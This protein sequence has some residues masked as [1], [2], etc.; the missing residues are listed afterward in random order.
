VSG[1]GEALLEYSSYDNQSA[2]LE[3]K[4]MDYTW[5]KKKMKFRIQMCDK[6]KHLKKV[7]VYIVTYLLVY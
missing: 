1:V 3:K 6:R 5:K 2:P 7:T 4:D